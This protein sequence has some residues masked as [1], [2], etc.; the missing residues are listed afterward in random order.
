MKYE[1]KTETETEIETEITLEQM[2]DK[3]GTRNYDCDNEM[4]WMFVPAAA[5]AAA[6]CGVFVMVLVLMTLT[7]D[8]RS[9]P[10]TSP[11]PCIPPLPPVYSLLLSFTLSNMDVRPGDGATG[12]SPTEMVV[13]DGRGD[14]AWF[15]MVLALTSIYDEGRSN[16]HPTL[17]TTMYYTRV[18]FA[19][20]SS[21]SF[22]LNMG[23]YIAR[24]QGQINLYTH[25]GANGD[26]ITKDEHIGCYIGHGYL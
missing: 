11:P 21:C 22:Q 12:T 15:Y 7:D 4:K 6:P 20:L 13:Q 5:A 10:P 24:T 25:D 16:Q 2:P 17:S 26:D 19:N 9:D 1:N 8:D 3:Y 18:L 14:N 23:V